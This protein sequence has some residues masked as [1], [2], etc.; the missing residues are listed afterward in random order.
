M[1]NPMTNN[2]ISGI[3]FYRNS[4]KC[5]VGDLFKDICGNIVHNKRTLKMA[6]I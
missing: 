6:E 2:Y 4:L 5:T 3:I 1:C